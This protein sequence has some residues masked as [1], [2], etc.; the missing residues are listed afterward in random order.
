MKYDDAALKPWRIAQEQEQAAAR[1]KRRYAILAKPATR[2]RAAERD[3]AWR[4]RA[5]CVDA[6]PGDFYALDGSE[7]QRRALTTCAVC[8]VKAECCEYAEALEDPHGVWGG[9]RPAERSNAR[10]NAHRER[11]R[12]GNE[13]RATERQSRQAS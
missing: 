12:A 10:R 13:R 6:D 4:A 8:P 1:Q 7:E 11:V 2:A 5:A 3:P 9:L